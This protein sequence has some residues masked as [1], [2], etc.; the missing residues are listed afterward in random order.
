MDSRSEWD[1]PNDE[2]RLVDSDASR[3]RVERRADRLVGHSGYS[4][5]ARHGTADSAIPGVAAE[6]K[7]EGITEAKRF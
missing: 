1:E 7:R 6:A 4:V 5:T 3:F 2:E